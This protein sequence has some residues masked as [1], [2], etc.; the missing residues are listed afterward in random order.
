MKR[1]Y[2]TSITDQ[3]IARLHHGLME[4]KSGFN[5]PIVRKYL[6]SKSSFSESKIYPMQFKPWDA[7]Y[8]YCELQSS[9]CCRPSPD[10]MPHVW[11]GN[12]FIVTRSSGVANPEGMPLF[13]TR[14]LVE[15]DQMR[16]HARLFP[17]L[18]KQSRTL[19]SNSSRR[20]L[21]Q[22]Q[23]KFFDYQPSLN[24]TEKDSQTDITA[25]ISSNARAYLA[26]LGIENPDEDAETA[27]L[28]WMH[29]LAIG[30]SPAYLSENA[31]GIRNDWPRVPLP[32]DADALQASAELGRAIAAILA[33]DAG[34]SAQASS[35]ALRGIIT[36][37]LRPEM[38]VIG[39]ISHA[40]G[41][42]LR[43]SAD[44][45]TAGDLALTVNWGYAGQKGV[46]MPG[47]GKTVERDYT[48]E[49]RAAIE[50]GAATL[51]LTPA[52]AFG[53]LG[54]TT[55]DVYLNDVAYWK[56]I[57]ARV[58]DYHIGG[59][60]VIKKW[61]SY[62]EHDLLGRDLTLAEA[63]EVRDMARRIT[64]LRLLEPALDANYQAIKA[65]SYSWPAESI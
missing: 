51:G 5:P 59:Y 54:E 49:E 35:T 33:Y 32:L 23:Q 65:L 53:R 16:G 28:I 31:D 6:L 43:L 9:L 15:R 34:D 4:P 60:Q 47:K 11:D 38:K 41:K 25:N 26:S 13:F 7:R 21:L 22:E 44:P 20:S 37:P 17:I 36:T 63:N 55:I 42:Q 27:A 2:D 30:Y 50:E 52:E 12:S 56:N 1:Y 3:E 48:A 14:Q 39:V 10:L 61:L 62:R 29:A 24:A 45:D 19:S 58:W 40:E 64:A 18:I 57:P 8:Y 46:T